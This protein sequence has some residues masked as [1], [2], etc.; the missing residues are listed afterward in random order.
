MYC[1]CI[2]FGTLCSDDAAAINNTG[3]SM[4]EWCFASTIFIP[5]ITTCVL[6]IIRIATSGATIRFIYIMIPIWFLH[7][8]SGYLA[9][10]YGR[11]ATRVRRVF[12]S[13][14]NLCQMIVSTFTGPTSAFIVFSLGTILSE[15]I[16]S[17]SDV[18]DDFEAIRGGRL[19]PL[20][21]GLILLS[22]Y[23]LAD[24][25]PRMYTLCGRASREYD[26][27]GEYDLEIHRLEQPPPVPAAAL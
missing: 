17:T 25:I 18:D 11:R 2:P 9:W 10:R 27:A 5:L 13:N 15:I 3:Q 20:I 1:Q 19:T 7:C 6:V 21:A 26:R 16:T 24:G 23:A 4:M 8:V 22:L 12:R 14:P